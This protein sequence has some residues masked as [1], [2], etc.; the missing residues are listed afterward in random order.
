MKP[1]R[2]FFGVLKVPL[3]FLLT[4]AAYLIALKLRTIDL[5]PWLQQPFDAT[6]L[7]T[8]E[9]YLAFSIKSALLLVVIFAINQMYELRTSRPLSREL[10][11]L[12]FLIFSWI[13]F[14]IA[15]YFIMRTF[16][17]S[18]LVLMYATIITTLLLT[19]ERIIIH[20]TKHALF[21][22]GI[23]QYRVAVI[24]DSEFTNDL[25][26]KFQK[27]IDYKY[28]GR[29]GTK[30]HHDEEKYL[31]SEEELEEIIKK[32]DLD[33]IIQSD[34]QEE[35]GQEILATCRA[36]HIKYSFVP[37]LL[38]VQRTNIQISTM[39]GIPIIELKPTPL[40]GWGKIIKRTF[41]IVGST[42]GL[43]IISPMLLI[44][45]IAIKLDSRGPALFKR[46]DNGAPVLRV[47]QH[48]KL[49]RF[50]KLRTMH[51]NTHNQRYTT[52]ADNNLRKDS[53]LVKIKDDPRIT[54]IGKFLR[55]FS[56]D[57][58]PQLWNVL[59][60]NMSLVG[61][62]PHFPEEVDKYSV[63]DKFVLEI[64]PGITGI[65]QISGR[66]DLDFKEE[67]RL[68]TYYIQNWSLDLDIK[69]LFRTIFAVLR[70][71]KE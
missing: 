27:H 39:Q 5:A 8:S 18:R 69:I 22:R 47:G 48:G 57:E 54:R 71:Y 13:M 53:P 58:L 29:I 1:I 55:R 63:S 6:T 60:G 16:P 30:T 23:G 70:G 35:K 41:D 64:K 44:S 33:Q 45:A 21:R 42:I 28:A 25:I 51:P 15:Y 62:R 9:N 4:I 7:P 36:N 56:I 67:I 38:D 46:L 40:D 2:L 14:I 61:P 3:D 24:G 37:N 17:F 10:G 65:S 34:N 20:Y 12:F 32:Y 66:S 43:M 49:F 19:L 68:D 31:G 59:I 52:L 26:I 11:K 50:Y